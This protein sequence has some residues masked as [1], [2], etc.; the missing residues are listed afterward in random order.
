M[1]IMMHFKRF[2]KRRHIDRWFVYN[3]LYA[4]CISDLFLHIVQLM[5]I[6]TTSNMITL[7]RFFFDILSYEQMKE[8]IRNLLIDVK[9]E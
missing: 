1:I 8:V 3:K 9:K 7:T 5:Q 4:K 2:H 6:K